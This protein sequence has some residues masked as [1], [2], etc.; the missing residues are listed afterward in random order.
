[1]LANTFAY[2]PS[3]IDKYSSYYEWSINLAQSIASG[4]T[5]VCKYY[6]SRNSCDASNQLSIELT[7]KPSL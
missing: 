5:N 2:R 6:L 3:F 1:M 4:T 7:M